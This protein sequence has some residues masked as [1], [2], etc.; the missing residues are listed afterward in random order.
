MVAIVTVLIASA[1]YVVVY[2]SNAANYYLTTSELKKT[3]P[4]NGERIR[5]AGQVLN[6]TVKNDAKS[7]VLKFVI[8]DDEG[9]ARI[10]VSFDGL[11]PGTFN[12][13]AKVIAEGVYTRGSVKADNLLVRCPEN[14]LPEEAISSLANTVKTEGLLYR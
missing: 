12:P 1:I 8:A 2:R 10:P 7:G 6:E 3:Q 5:V 4:G 11:V 14:Y 9:K 13:D